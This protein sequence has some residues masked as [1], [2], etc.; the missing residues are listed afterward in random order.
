[1]NTTPLQSLERHR[2][3]Q[4]V[5]AKFIENG[6]T[7]LRQIP[8][9][10][11]KSSWKAPPLQHTHSS[12]LRSSKN[13]ISTHIYI[14]EPGADARLQSSL[15]VPVKRRPLSPDVARFPCCFTDEQYKISV[16]DRRQD[17][18][19][20]SLQN[21]P[22]QAQGLLLRRGSIKIFEEKASSQLKRD[23]PQSSLEAH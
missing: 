14:P 23:R 21:C 1:M 12:C 18:S 7:N 8:E 22:R 6:L 10:S 5:H 17:N 16:P 3:G 15:L 4:K 2:T 13:K 19:G 11:S 20:K 9:S